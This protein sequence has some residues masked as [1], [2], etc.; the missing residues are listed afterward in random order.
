MNMAQETKSEWASANRTGDTWVVE[1]SD[2]LVKVTIQ[3]NL[4]HTEQE[5]VMPDCLEAKATFHY[6]NGQFESNGFSE[7]ATR[8]LKKTMSRRYHEDFIRKNW[9]K[10]ED[11]ELAQ[12][13]GLTEG[14]IKTLRGPMGLRRR[15][16]KT[17]RLHET[18]V[19][20]HLQRIEELRATGKLCSICE[21][22]EV[23]SGTFC[24]GCSG[25]YTEQMPISPAI[26]EAINAGI[27]VDCRERTHFGGNTDPNRISFAQCVDCY[28]GHSK[29]RRR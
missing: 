12:K 26:I 8:W 28:T 27:C 10:M 2:A 20:N 6:E 25:L 3:Q 17:E 7:L 24:V 22:N 9:E 29:K 15:E 13:L 11:D 5:W 16:L 19:A 21:K 1:A 4:L 18:K 14:A 23:F